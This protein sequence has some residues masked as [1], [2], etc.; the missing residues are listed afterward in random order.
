METKGFQTFPESGRAILQSADGPT[1][2]DENPEQ[3]AGAMFA[4]DIAN[5]DSSLRAIKACI[6]DRGFP[7]I[8]GYLGL[9][10]IDVPMKVAEA[11]RNLRYS[12]PIFLAPPW[13]EIFVNDAERT[14]SFAES[15]ETSD[16]VVAAW[17]SYGYEPI[18]LPQVSVLQRAEFIFRNLT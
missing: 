17:Q 16:A 18:L 7:D 10:K 5:F 14:Q 6:F 11:C 8:V 15:C 2:R 3:Y 4:R 12:G 13:E 9:M 1:L